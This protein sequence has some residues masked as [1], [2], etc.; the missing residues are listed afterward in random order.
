MS[1]SATRSRPASV[2]K[3]ANSDSAIIA[4]KRRIQKDI[5]NLYEDFG[6]V[7][8]DYEETEYGE[9]SEKEEEYE[10][11]YHEDPEYGSECCAMC[12]GDIPMEDGQ[13]EEDEDQIDEGDDCDQD[14]D[15]EE[16]NHGQ[17][18]SE[19]EMKEKDDDDKDSERT[20]KVT[21]S[22]DEET[23]TAE[24]IEPAWHPLFKPDA[25]KVILLSNNNQKL[26]VD[27]HTLS[28][29]R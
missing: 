16:S 29:H 27:R 9:D 17:E 19:V 21:G 26:C 13:D 8:D 4:K 24:S 28:S 6:T 14:K 7:M 20:G 23:E 3:D 1:S 15:E 18:K 25:P 2:S 5:R 10:M 22:D 12:S 11:D